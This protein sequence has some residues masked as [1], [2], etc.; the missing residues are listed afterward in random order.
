MVA[1]NVPCPDWDDN[2]IL[3][4]AA[5]RHAGPGHNLDDHDAPR[6]HGV[7]IAGIPMS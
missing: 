2:R 4:L 6:S 3:D 5:A 7:I 1:S